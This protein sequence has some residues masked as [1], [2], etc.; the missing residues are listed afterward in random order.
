M[1]EPAR[2]CCY[3]HV[4]SWAHISGGF[5]FDLSGPNFEI[6]LPFCFIRMGWTRVLIINVDKPPR[7]LTIG[8][9]G[10]KSWVESAPP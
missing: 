10:W 5:H 1:N 8:Y 3:L 9:D 2:F 4:T 6:H 7:D